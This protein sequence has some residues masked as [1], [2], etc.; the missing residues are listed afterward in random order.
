VIG[1]GTKSGDDAGRNAQVSS[2]PDQTA[3][4]ADRGV[5]ALT[6]GTVRQAIIMA[7]LADGRG[8][9][10]CRIEFLA[11]CWDRLGPTQR[12]H[13]TIHCQNVSDLA[14]RLGR[15]MGETPAALERLRLAGL[16]HDIGKCAIPE[17]LLAKPA[18]LTP[19]ERSVLNHHARLGAE[20]AA[21]LGAEQDIVN[22]VRHH[23][24]PYG[25]ALRRLRV[26]GANRASA[27]EPLPGARLICVADAIVSMT[28]RRPYCAARSPAEALAE[29]HR[30][31]GRQ[32]DPRVVELVQSCGE[33]VAA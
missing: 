15:T 26:A 23:H 2:T 20:I 24:T 17:L 12:E 9:Q 1:K 16:L 11:R 32:F 30:C 8:P 5:G 14:V 4:L 3:S 22:F 18:V 28:S 25:D 19:R 21:G 33:A 27:D 10:Q 7:R 29:L 13:L 31:A 6:V